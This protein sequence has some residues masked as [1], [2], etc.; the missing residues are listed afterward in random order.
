MDRNVAI[1]RHT[2]E[3]ELANSHAAEI[4]ISVFLITLNEAAHIEQVLSSVAW[5]DEVIVLDSG[6]TD[7]TTDICARMG[8]QLHH[9]NGWAIQPKRLRR[10]PNVATLGVSILTVMKSLPRIS[11][12]SCATGH[13]TTA[14]RRLK[15]KLMT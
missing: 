11:R 2:S 14:F 10:W 4:P 1:A 15:S 9:Q 13:A 6:S 5:A 12:T 3:N 7:G 8:V